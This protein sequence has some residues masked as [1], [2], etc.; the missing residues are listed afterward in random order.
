MKNTKYILYFKLFVSIFFRKKNTI[1]KKKLIMSY[2]FMN[3]TSDTK[4]YTKICN[5]NHLI[6]IDIVCYIYCYSLICLQL[7]I[8]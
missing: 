4:L 2:L 6:L 3:N 5:P 7:M 8:W 1:L